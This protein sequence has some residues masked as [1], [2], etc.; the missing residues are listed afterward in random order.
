[1]CI[2]PRSQ[3]RNLRESLVAF[4]GTVRR[5]PFRGKL[6]LSCKKRFEE[7]FFEL[8]RL[9]VLLRSVMHTVVSNFL[10]FVID[11][12]SEIETKFKNIL[13]CLSGA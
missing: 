1:M 5:I 9:K 8:L 3:N 13:A 12:L 7:N 10:N 4:K 6:F 11:Y 2:T